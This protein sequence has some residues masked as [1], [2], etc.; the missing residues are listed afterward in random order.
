VG[1]SAKRIPFDCKIARG[2][3]G[4]VRAVEQGDHIL[5]APLIEKDF[6]F[7]KPELQGPICAGGRKVLAG[8]LRSMLCGIEIAV[9][10][11]ATNALK[12][13]RRVGNRRRTASSEDDD[14]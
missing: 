8:F 3:K 14:R 6:G 10:K 1:Y 4:H 13:R 11:I 9:Q 12:Y 5:P 2:G 7:E